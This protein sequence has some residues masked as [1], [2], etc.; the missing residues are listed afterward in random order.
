[1]GLDLDFIRRIFSHERYYFEVLIIVF[2]IIE[3]I[4]VREN[5]SEIGVKDIYLFH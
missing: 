4:A 1:M 3:G 5:L 2:I